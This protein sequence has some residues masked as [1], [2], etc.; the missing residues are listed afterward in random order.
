MGLAVRVRIESEPAGVGRGT[1]R[2]RAASGAARLID[3]MWPAGMQ[4]QQGA[5]GSLPLATSRQPIHP[6]GLLGLPSG[7]IR[8]AIRA[9]SAARTEWRIL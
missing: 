3:R 4:R 9:S 2:D 1:I 5:V 8:L 6:L 7:R